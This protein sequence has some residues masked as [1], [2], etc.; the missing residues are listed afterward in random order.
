MLPIQLLHPSAKIPT[1]AHPSDAAFDCYC[2]SEVDLKPGKV[3]KVSL[4]FS[5]EL[6]ENEPVYCQIASRSGLASKGVFA[7]GGVIDP[8]YRGELV[9]LLFNSTDE[10]FHLNSGDRC[11][12]LLFLMFAQTT[13][14]EVPM[15][16]PSR[17]GTGG[18]GSTGGV[19]LG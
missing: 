13:F 5:L 18:L 3:S 16:A 7:V 14:V 1:K 10:D 11:C 6:P 17:R 9:A 8:G 12:Q 15:L 4:G 19:L 2:V